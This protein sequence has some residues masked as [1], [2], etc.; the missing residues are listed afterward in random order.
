MSAKS[1]DEINPSINQPTGVGAG[2]GS[3]GNK[4]Q[5]DRAK[6]SIR[7]A[8]DTILQRLRGARAIKR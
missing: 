8:V 4:A 2:D 6:Q 1:A 5:G 3:V 7:E